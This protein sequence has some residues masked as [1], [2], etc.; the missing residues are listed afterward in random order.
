MS[1]KTSD[2][3]LANYF[4]RI[5]MG[6]HKEVGEKTHKYRLDDKEYLRDENSGSNDEAHLQKSV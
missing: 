4:E 3:T 6:I 1:L 5:C 2:R